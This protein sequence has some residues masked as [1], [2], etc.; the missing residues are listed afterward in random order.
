MEKDDDLGDIETTGS[1]LRAE[2]KPSCKIVRKINEREIEKVK[3]K[4]LEFENIEGELLRTPKHR[5][6]LSRH[7]SST[8]QP[9]Q[10]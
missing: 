6:K 1:E 8:I 3:G 5:G 7:T 10:V 2:V 4:K 9:E